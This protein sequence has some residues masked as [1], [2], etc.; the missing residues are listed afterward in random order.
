MKQGGTQSQCS[1][2]TQGIG[3][4]EK[5]EVGSGSGG[6]THTCGQ[7]MLMYVKNYYNIV[8]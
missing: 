8:K 3:W 2:T 6:H 4:E 7:L 5:W 1:G